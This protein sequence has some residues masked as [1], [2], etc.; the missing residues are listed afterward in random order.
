MRSFVDIEYSNLSSLMNAMSEYAGITYRVVNEVLHSSIAAEYP[1]NEISKLIPSSGRNWKGKKAAAN[2]VNPWKTDTSENLT[3]AIKSKKGYN[4][5]YFPDDGSNTK[6]HQG[7][8]HFMQRGVD[9]SMP[10]ILELCQAQIIDEMNHLI[11]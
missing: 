9:A 8:Q 4:Y 2:S 11:K 6:R 3:L 5:L 10:K 7:E 1:I